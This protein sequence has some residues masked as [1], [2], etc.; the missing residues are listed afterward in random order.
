MHVC[1]PL[2]ITRRLSPPQH[3]RSVVG[4]VVATRTTICL[5]AEDIHIEFLEDSMTS[6]KT[7]ISRGFLCRFPVDFFMDLSRN[8]CRFLCGF[9]CGFLGYAFF[10]QNQ[11]Q[12]LGTR[13][14][15]SEKSTENFTRNSQTNSPRNSW[16]I[17]GEVHGE[18]HAEIHMTHMA[19]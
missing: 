9:R 18:I 16:D 15:F 11:T 1:Q 6:E 8:Y 3:F 10:K 5:F 13:N 14:I 2:Q 4:R 7:W 19:T 12:C 17:H